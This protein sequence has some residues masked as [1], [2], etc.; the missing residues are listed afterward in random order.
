[1]IKKE[2]KESESQIVSKT[3]EKEKTAFNRDIAART[4]RLRNPVKIFT[5]FYQTFPDIGENDAVLF[6]R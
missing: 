2:M 3:K 5:S 6:G 1:M 4:E